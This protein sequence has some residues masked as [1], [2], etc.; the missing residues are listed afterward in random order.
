M[1]VARNGVQRAGRGFGRHA[2]LRRSPPAA[3]AGA[4]VGITCGILLA[5]FF[6]QRFGTA[7][8]SFLFS[9]VILLW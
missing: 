1:R 9:P 4:V 2:R 5:L 7:R 3:A 6:I 8:V